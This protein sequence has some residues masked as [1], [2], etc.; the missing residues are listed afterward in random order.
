MV[1]DKNYK[2]ILLSSED[3]GA[4]LISS[5][6][7]GMMFKFRATGGSMAPFISHNSLV[8]VFPY[9]EKEPETGDMAA[10]IHPVT[11]KLILHRIIDKKNKKYL[12]KGDNINI[13]D[14]WFNKEN[15]Y[16]YVKN[17][18]KYEKI[19]PYVPKKFLS[20]LSRKGIL[21]PFLKKIRTFKIM[22]NKKKNK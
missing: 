6:K 2:E 19:L 3:A 15:V 7:K 10:L 13:A 11:K 12:F 8:T 17:V 16:G 22:I 18:T 20:C 21:T 1:S 4:L 9:L 14:G 5:C